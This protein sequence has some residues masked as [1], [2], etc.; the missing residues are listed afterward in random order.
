MRIEKDLATNNDHVEKLDVQTNAH[1]AQENSDD[2]IEPCEQKMVALK[3]PTIDSPE[4]VYIDQYDLLSKEERKTIQNLDLDLQ[5][6]FLVGRIIERQSSFVQGQRSLF[7]NE[8]AYLKTKHNE[9]LTETTKGIYILGNTNNLNKVESTISS[10]GLMASGIYSMLHDKKELGLGAFVVGALLAIDTM[11]DN[12]MKRTIAQFLAKS[13][14]ETEETWLERVQVFTSVSTLVISLGLSQQEAINIGM[15][16]SKSALSF[17]RG[18]VER[19]QG[20]QK[21]ILIELDAE[22]EKSER[23]IDLLM[24]RV[25]E[26]VT[27]L[28]EFY[29]NL[30]QIRSNRHQTISKLTH[31][32]H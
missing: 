24:M 22:V 9:R 8:N 3:A 2:F 25:N 6:D 14:D 5:F 16:V 23:R 26:I 32:K 7:E 12:S 19:Q 31:V 28:L 29:E 30:H 4:D 11:L 1:I 18:D 21:A 27:T 15:N 20:L 10:F 17:V 13:T